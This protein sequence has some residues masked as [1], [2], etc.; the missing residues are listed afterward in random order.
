LCREW[1]TVLRTNQLANG[2]L[3]S[4]AT[5]SLASQPNTSDVVETDLISVDSQD[6]SALDVELNATNSS[7][8]SANY[9]CKLK[10]TQ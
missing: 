5:F 6:A 3:N 9:V 7:E 10:R 1:R 8:N 4:S 2:I